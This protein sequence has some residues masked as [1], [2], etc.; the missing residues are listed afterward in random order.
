M[1]TKIYSYSE[2][3]ENQRCLGSENAHYYSMN[4]TYQFFNNYKEHNRFG[5][6]HISAAHEDT[7]NVKTIDDDLLNFLIKMLELFDNK[8]E[9]L[10]IMLIGDHGR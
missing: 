1:A 8:Q 9:D 6:V 10:A 3:A 4:H 7:G 5:Y 2:F